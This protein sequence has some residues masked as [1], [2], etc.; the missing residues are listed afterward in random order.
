MGIFYEYVDIVNRAP[1]ALTVRFDGQDITLPPGPGRLPKLV[2]PFAQ[3]QNPINGTMD[4]NNPHRSGCKYLIAEVGYNEP[5]DCEMLTLEQ[6]EDH[7]KR[8]CRMDERAAFEERYGTDPKAKLVLLGKG[9][10]STATS[11]ADAGAAPRGA[12]EFAGDR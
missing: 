12:A 3:N 7:L 6:W 2:L 9:R 1:I 4:P 5:E 8:P 11:R 10:R